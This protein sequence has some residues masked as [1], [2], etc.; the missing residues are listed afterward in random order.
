MSSP[1][2]FVFFLYDASTGAPLAGQT[3]TFSTYKDTT[4]A[5]VSQ[6]SI[7]DLGGGA[8]SFVPVFPTDRGLAFVVNGGS[9][10]PPYQ[11]GFLR[12]EDYNVDILTLLQK[13]EEGRWKIF[14]TGADVNRLVIYDT[15]GTTPLIKFD[16]KDA[17]GSPTFVNPFERVK[18]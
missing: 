1:K 17:A 3:P 7:T 9:A 2:N 15:D 11:G 16:L 18:V 8:Y 4:G 10:S 5:N 14:T 6:P 13:Y 12:P